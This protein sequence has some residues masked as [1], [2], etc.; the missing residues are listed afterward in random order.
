MKA[1]DKLKHIFA[2][3]E[4]PRIERTKKHPFY[5]I[6][7]IS[8][9]SAI[10][11]IDDYVGM[12]DYCEENLEYFSTLIDL[13]AG[14]PSHDTIGR[15]LSK[16]DETKFNEAFVEFTKT[17]AKKIP[18]IIA[19]DGKTAR[20]SADKSQERSPLHSVSAWSSANSLVLAQIA[21]DDKSNEI[22]AIPKLLDMLDL[23]GEV[24]TIDAMGC[25]RVIAEKIIGK[26]GDYILSLKGNQGTLHDDIR[27]LFEGYKK[28]N[29]KTF[30]GEFFEEMEKSHGRIEIRK[31]WV[32]DHLGSLLLAHQWPG[33]K[34]V[35]MVSSERIINGKTTIEERF[36]ISSLGPVARRIASYI[37]LHWE[38]ENKVHWVL[39]V[40]FNE[41]RSQIRKDNG[42]VIMNIVRK[43]ALN[44][45]NQVKGKLS[46]RRMQNKVKMSTK[47][48]TEV[49]ATII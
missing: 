38:I 49:L 33:L 39:D 11:G 41:D 5:S 16:I 45:I 48:L 31:C 36:Y 40:T 37:R 6:L 34:T 7:F 9:C 2:E 22:T 18:G 17:I 43:W 12:E 14:T 42:P 47:R 25:Q 24:V 13:P 30:K 20:K 19:I 21:V 44:C 23:E 35:V 29:W 1:D 32:T 28:E 8:I 26:K 15:V 27:L 46:I 4:D 3:L 10:A